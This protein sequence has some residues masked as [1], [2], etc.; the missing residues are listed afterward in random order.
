MATHFSILAWEIQARFP[1]DGGAWQVTVHEVTKGS[2][3]IQQLNNNNSNDK[4]ET[5]RMLEEECLQRT[6]LL[7]NFL[8]DLGDQW[9]HLRSL[10]TLR[11]IAISKPSLTA[12]ESGNQFW[13]ST[14][15]LYRKEKKKKKNT[16]Q[17]AM[18]KFHCSSFQRETQVDFKGLGRRLF[19]LVPSKIFSAKPF[20]INLLVRIQVRVPALQS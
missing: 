19:I 16:V 7:Y 2:V 6:N 20:E 17:K 18:P 4:M 9:E 12:I 1:L 13:R 8:L 3:M 15:A 5:P 14:K 11:H 10:E